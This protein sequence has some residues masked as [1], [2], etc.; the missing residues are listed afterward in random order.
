M[1]VEHPKHPSFFVAKLWSYFVPTAP[2]AGTAA[3]LE[4]L[5]V[6]SGYAI[7]PVLEAILCSPQ[8]YTGPRMVKP[9]TVFVAGMLRARRRGITTNSWNWVLSGCG[10]VLYYRPTS[11]A[12][13]TS[14]GSTPT[15]RSGAGR[16]S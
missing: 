2:D 8:L 1:V 16:R 15:P 10:Q 4:Q 7:R 13:T 12:G 6:S 14:A 3:K 11:R 9:P 5:Y